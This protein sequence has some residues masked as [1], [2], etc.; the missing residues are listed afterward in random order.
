MACLRSSLFACLFAAGCLVACTTQS[1]PEGGFQRPGG[2]ADSAELGPCDDGMPAYCTLAEPSCPTGTIAALQGGCWT[3]ADADTCE[4]HG[5]PLNCDDGQ[6]AWCTLAEPA[7]PSGM[8]AALQDGC[9]TCADP[10]T[11]EPRGLPLN[12]DDGPAFCT[13]PAPEC[14]PGKVAASRDGCWSCVDPFTCE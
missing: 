3:C 2:K 4:P 13:I 14:A 7:C 10:F 8:V 12:C 9:W 11:C 5:L 1:E 6:P